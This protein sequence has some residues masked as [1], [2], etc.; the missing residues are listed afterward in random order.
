MLSL[1]NYFETLYEM[2]QKLI[3]LCGDIFCF[4][5]KKK[6]LEIIQDIPKVIPYSFNK[7]TCKLE[8]KEQDGILEFKNKMT[9]LEQNFHEILK[10]HYDFL[11]KI[12]II[13]N[14]CQHK[15]HSVKHLGHFSGPSIEF[16]YEFLIEIQNNEHVLK[17]KSKEFIGLFKELNYLYSKM[18]NEVRR[19]NYITGNAEVDAM[20]SRYHEKMS[21]FDFCK[22][23]DMFDSELLQTFGQSMLDF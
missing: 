1:I 9:Y 14:K 20:Y 13:R 23:N 5:S 15:I 17:V 16:E 18:Q 19:H 8:F 4:N 6:L 3:I 22:F 21:R 7:N 2:N 10:K 11:D 12:R